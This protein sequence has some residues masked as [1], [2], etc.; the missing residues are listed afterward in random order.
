[1]ND[2][3]EDL[4][5]DDDLLRL[6]GMTDGPREIGKF[7]LRPITGET[8]AWMQTVGIY[9]DEIGS[10]FRMA[11]YAFIHSQPK[12]EVLPLIF[13]REKFWLAVS[14]FIEEHFDHHE[15]LTPYDK[16]FGEQYE[17]Y[18]ASLTK[19]AHPSDGMESP[20]KN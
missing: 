1:M 4:T 10:V 7:T 3:Q 8:F 18:Q 15:S 17:I 9:D 16:I 5:T 13:K 20:I 14:D 11:A 19:A 6:Q 12:K 2:T